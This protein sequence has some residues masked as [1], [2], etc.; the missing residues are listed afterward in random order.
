MGGTRERVTVGV[1]C[2]GDFVFKFCFIGWNG[3]FRSGFAA[4]LANCRPNGI[5][6]FFILVRKEASFS[7][8]I[9]SSGHFC[10]KRPKYLGGYRIAAKPVEEYDDSLE[11]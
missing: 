6:I 2:V 7:T 8:A 10:Q 9:G 3:A 11:K 4:F 5:R 1:H